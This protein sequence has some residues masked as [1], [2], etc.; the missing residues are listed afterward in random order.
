[1][2]FAPSVNNSRDRN[3]RV[4]ELIARMSRGE[5]SAMGDLYDL[6]GTD[7]YAYALSK[8][9][10]KDDSEDVTHDTFIQIWKSAKQYTPMGKPLAWIF[11]IEINIIRKQRKKFKASIPFD[12]SI[13]GDI[14]GGDF[15]ENVILSDFLNQM[16]NCLQEEERE[17]V[18]LHTVSEMKHR[19]IAK[20][21]NKPLSTVLSKYNRAI[22]KIQNLLK[23][24]EGSK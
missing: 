22:K 5:I 16:L 19:E 6:I 7:V 2:I 17:I 8:S 1:M 3:F 11:T 21:L 15:T 18:V 4:E 14:D 13:E 10:N 12:E 9:V 24:K 20:L 23:E